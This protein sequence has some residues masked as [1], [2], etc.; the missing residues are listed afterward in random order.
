MKPRVPKFWTFGGGKGGVGKSFLTSAIGV[1]LARKN[2][3]VIAI[4]AD[5]GSA[6][7]HTYLGIKNPTRTLLDHLENGLSAEEVLLPTYQSGLQLISCAGDILGMA[8]PQS[9]RKEK[10]MEFITGLRA[11]FILVD[12]GAGTSYTVLD[13]FNMSHE[14]IVIVTPDP[15]SM[16]SAYAF[17]KSAIYRRIQMEYSYN[18]AVIQALNRCMESDV[19][20]RPRT[21]MEF[22]ELVCTTDPAIAES[23]ATM[24]G[25]FEPLLL[26][27]LAGSAQDK[28]VAEIMQSASKKFLNVNIRLGGLITQDAIIRK[29]CQRMEILA[30]EDPANK[31]AKEI[32][33]V[34]NCLLNAAGEGSGVQDEAAPIPSTPTIGLNDNLDF[35]GKQIHIQTED[36]GFSGRSI[37][38]QVFCEG[39][40]ILSTKSEYPA[41]LKSRNNPAEIAEL[42]RKQH[43]NVIRELESKKVRILH[44]T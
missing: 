32:E 7:L 3:S 15:A 42:M 34:V 24:V 9:A 43:F 18:E 35:M 8:N 40:V 13:F 25:R 10:I 29:S 11:D 21:M 6:N 23:V 41:S 31:P 12:L 39:R 17:I 36:M 22:Y 16:Q 5:L 28:R 33:D 2:K 1:A 30:F 14:G 38:T 37:S 20:H 26:I 44:S 19:T 4:D 27:N